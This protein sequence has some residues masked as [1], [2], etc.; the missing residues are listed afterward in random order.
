MFEFLCLFLQAGGFLK[1]HRAL[2]ESR[3]AEAEPDLVRHHGATMVQH[4]RKSFG[5][6]SEV[7]K[8]QLS[9]WEQDVMAGAVLAWPDQV[10]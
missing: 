7:P 6:E 3:P 4:C 8:K 2:A 9:M 10:T 1:Q 5:K